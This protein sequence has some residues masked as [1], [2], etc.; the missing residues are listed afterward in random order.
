MGDSIAGGDHFAW[1][2]WRMGWLS[3]SQVRCVTAASRAEFVVS[4]VETRGGVKAVILRTGLQT[5]VVVEYRTRQGL[6]ARMCSTGVLVYKV[7]STLEGG[8]GP[9]RVSDARPRS[10]RAGRSCGAELDDAAYRRGGRWTDSTSGIAIDVTYVGQAARIRVSRSKTFTPPVRV[11]RSIETSI[12][13]NAHSTV[14]VSAVIAA[15]SAT[16]AAGRALSLQELRFGEWWTIRTANTDGT[17]GW[18]HTL[19]PTP[20]ASHRLRAPQRVAAALEC[21]LAVSSA[22]SVP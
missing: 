6:D 15:S 1:D 10:A 2:K 5:A 3:D 17:G 8:A 12:T 16:C 19:T 11:E 18:T 14:T 20:G 21:A 7:N 22:L 9:I 13:A 4:P